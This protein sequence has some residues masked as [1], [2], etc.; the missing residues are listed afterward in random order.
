[1]MENRSFD[2]MLG[3][4]ALMGRDVEGLTGNEQ[5]SLA[6]VPRPFRV[7]HTTQTKGIP[8]PG[9]HLA[10]VAEQ[11]AGGEMSGFVA[12][13]NKRPGVTDPGLVMSFY[14]ESELP[15]Y[16][17]I[18]DNFAICDTWFSA[19]AGPTWPNRFCAT[20]G[21]APELENFDISDDR[22]GYF[23]GTSIFDV[24]TQL[25][26][27]WAYA[28]SNIAFLRMFDRY[29][30]DVRRIIPFTDDFEQG[31]DDT[32]E[33]RVR[34]GRLPSVSFI[35]PRYIDVPPAFDANDDLPPTDVCHG[36]RLVR[37]VYELLRQAPTWSRTLFLVTYDE[38]GGFHD[39]VAPPGT[40][41]STSPESVPRIHPDGSDHLGVRVPALVVSPWVDAGSVI[42]TRFDHTSIIKT[43]LDRFAPKGVAGGEAFGPRTAQASSL[44]PELRNT[45]RSDA[46]VPP[47]I[48]CKPASPAQRGPATVERAD[49]H[50]T[51]RFLG[52]PQHYREA[53]KL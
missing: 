29:R 21:S 5:N 15:M 41:A 35:D 11:V 51:M 47:A 36:Q 8:S 4:R 40:P 43:I 23:T 53:L 45:P 25:G 52:V 18:A 30:L 32:F 9:H 17:F 7:E 10:D 46:P 6:G 19:H 42:K 26:V 24:L 38:H 28:E 31:I 27:D 2:H 1:M 48:T 3:Y 14:T 44:L 33:N 34:A 22:I 39:H 50:T 49:Y 16:D 20:T 37:R 13:Y 12:N